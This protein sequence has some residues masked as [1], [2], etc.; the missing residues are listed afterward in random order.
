MGFKS[1]FLL[2]V[3]LLSGSESWGQSP[4]RAA[5]RVLVNDAVG[6]Q[7]S[8]LND[9]EL[10]AGR[11]FRSAGIEVV[12]ANCAD[13]HDC[14][15]APGA[16]EFVLHIVPSGK[17]RSESVFGEAFLGEDGQGKYVDVFLD[18][19]RSAQ[20]QVGEARL[21]GTVS[22]HELGHLLLGARSH[23][24][25]G[26]MQAR[27]AGESLRQIGVGS[28]MFTPSEA[29]SMRAHIAA[30]S[31]DMGRGSQGLSDDTNAAM[32]TMSSTLRFITWRRICLESTPERA[33][34]LMSNNCRTM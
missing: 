2:G 1:N 8:V 33:P 25:V 4:E 18:R 32:A 21:L 19:I 34:V 7:P 27:W 6:V 24:P 16:N 29:A 17:T 11:L 9:A 13:T 3:V 26:L 22:A 20:G 28:L 12:W 15:R 14:R 31:A 23:S 10:E 5:I 30:E